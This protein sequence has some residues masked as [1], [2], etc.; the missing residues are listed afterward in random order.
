MFDAV[1]T[2]VTKDEDGIT[3]TK[4][5]RLEFESEADFQR[6]LHYGATEP[7]QLSANA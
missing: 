3:I 4:V 1:V 2:F 6:W 7:E 5:Y